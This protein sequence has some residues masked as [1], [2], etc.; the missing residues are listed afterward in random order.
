MTKFT[1]T[2]AASAVILAA[3]TATHAA[4]GEDLYF[5]VGVGSN[6]HSNSVVVSLNDRSQGFGTYGGLS[7]DLDVIYGKSYTLG[8]VALGLAA[9]G[10]H[11]TFG[12]SGRVAAHLGDQISIHVDVPMPVVL[13]STTTIGRTLTRAVTVGYHRKW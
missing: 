3:S 5:G 11:G 9:H 12:F 1:A 7:T 10:A 4:E 13:A 2:L 8:P 6:A